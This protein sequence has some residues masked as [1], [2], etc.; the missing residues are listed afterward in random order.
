[1]VSSQQV[2]RLQ[3]KEINSTNIFSQENFFNIILVMKLY[4]E[5]LRKK[6]ENTNCVDDI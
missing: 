2:K 5:W 3:E 6:L 4:I 1:M